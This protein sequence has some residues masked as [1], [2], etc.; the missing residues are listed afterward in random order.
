M[1]SFHFTVRSGVV[2][3]VVNSGDAVTVHVVMNDNINK[4]APLPPRHDVSI[5]REDLK[6][7]DPRAGQLY[8][9]K[10]VVSGLGS[11]GVGAALLAKGVLTDRY[12]APYA[13]SS[14]DSEITKVPVNS[15]SGNTPYSVDD[16]QPFPIYGWLTLTWQRAGAA[17]LRTIR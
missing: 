11:F 13:H 7:M 2:V 15:L 12:D 14:H 16:S 6:R 17:P 1:V 3:H 10:E 9:A 8:L 5:S 4:R